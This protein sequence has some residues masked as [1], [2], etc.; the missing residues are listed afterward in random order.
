MITRGNAGL[1]GTLVH[2]SRGLNHQTVDIRNEVDVI[3]GGLAIFSNGLQALNL[4]RL[5][6]LA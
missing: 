6:D 1:A 5:I 2:E 3:L 4:D